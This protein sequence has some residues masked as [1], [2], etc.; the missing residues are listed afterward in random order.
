MAALR[1][2]PIP[3]IVY[4]TA[5]KASRTEE[6][7]LQALNSGFRAIDTAAQPKHYQEHLVGSAV[8]KFISTT[9]EGVKRSDLHIQTKFTSLPGQDPS[10]GIPYDPNDSLEDQVHSSIASS[11]KN[12]TYS[13]NSAEAPYLDSLVLHSPLP[14]ISETLRVWRVL[15]SYVPHS[16]RSLGISNIYS[17]PALQKLYTEAKIK[18]VVVQNRFCRDLD[19]GNE[20]YAFCKANGI[21]FQSFWTLTANP[22]LLRSKTVR[23]LAA[24]VG[25]SEQAALYALLVGRGGWSVLN[26][27]TREET[28]KGDL[29]ALERIDAWQTGNSARAVELGREFE[30]LLEI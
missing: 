21:V 13:D 18:P 24:D 26:G 15:E 3:R 17:L 23:T 7:V 1:A 12:F 27:T 8:R 11:L 28:M 25:T 16:I 29:E 22:D 30:G 6:L 10:K 19:Y 5:W 2:L 9:K 20:I 4:G 14:T